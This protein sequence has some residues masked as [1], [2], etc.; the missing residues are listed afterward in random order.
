MYVSVTGF[1][2]TGP[3]AHYAYSDIVGQAMGGVMTRTLHIGAAEGGSDGKRFYAAVDEP[4]RTE[5]FVIS[6]AEAARLMRDRAEFLE[7]K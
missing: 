2:Q 1:G 3:H 5:V 4:G 6:E 7:K